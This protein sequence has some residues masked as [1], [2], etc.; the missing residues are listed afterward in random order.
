MADNEK[1][2]HL[3]NEIS[4]LLALLIELKK[5]GQFKEALEN[6]DHTLLKYFNCDH[7]FIYSV[8]EDFLIDAL[9]EEKG[10]SIEELSSLAEVLHEKGDILFKQN[11]LKASNKILRNALKIYFFLNENQD[12]FSFKNMNKMILINDKLAKINLKIEN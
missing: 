10:L 9:K 1:I 3:I 6:V 8:S 11:N 7:Q 4:N 5:K 12:F 2:L